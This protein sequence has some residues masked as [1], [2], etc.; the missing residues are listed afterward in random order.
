MF[1]KVGLKRLNK[2]QKSLNELLKS[3]PNTY[4]G[5]RSNFFFLKKIYIYYPFQIISVHNFGAGY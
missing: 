5:P 4:I 2:S 3:R 1:L